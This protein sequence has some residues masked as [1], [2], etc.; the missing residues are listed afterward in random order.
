M[1]MT[2]TAAHASIGAAA[3]ELHLPTIRAE[4]AQLAEIAVRERQSYLAFLAEAPHRRSRRTRQPPPLSKDHRS[5][6][7]PP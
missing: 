2:D 3:R 7:S 5:P 4:A 6:F 1:T